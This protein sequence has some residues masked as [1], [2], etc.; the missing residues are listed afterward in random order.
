MGE[1]QKTDRPCMDRVF[2][3]GGSRGERRGEQRVFMGRKESRERVSEAES[4][5]A[6]EGGREQ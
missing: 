5:R 4:K 6:K 3:R 1:R 2:F